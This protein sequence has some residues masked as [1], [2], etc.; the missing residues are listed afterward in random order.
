MI[1]YV[2]GFTIGSNPSPDG[3]GFTVT[4]EQGEVIEQQFFKKK[5]FTNN[6]GELLGLD[7]AC[8]VCNSG[9]TIRSDSRTALAWVKSGKCKGR[10]DLWSIVIRAK[11]LV[12]KKSLVLAWT[13]RESNRAGHVND[14]TKMG[15]GN[16]TMN[17]PIVDMTVFDR[18]T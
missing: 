5:D 14:L 10:P 9:D 4:D 13:P 3:G 1:Y 17:R 6:E 18:L 8:M 15:Y 16:A 12:E 7:Y 11:M 2:D